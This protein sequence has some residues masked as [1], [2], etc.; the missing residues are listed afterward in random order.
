MDILNKKIKDFITNKTTNLNVTYKDIQSESKQL[1]KILINVYTKYNLDYN[2]IKLEDCS[3]YKTYKYANMPEFNIFRY[4]ASSHRYMITDINFNVLH[5]DLPSLQNIVALYPEYMEYSEIDKDIILKNFEIKITKFGKEPIKINFTS[6]NEAKK[7][8]LGQEIYRDIE[9]STSNIP[10]GDPTKNLKHIFQTL[11]TKE[12]VT[13][14]K[15]S[16]DRGV[17]LVKIYYIKN[18]NKEYT[19]DE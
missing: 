6:F 4:G 1:K 9:Y 7:L 12:F 14:I 15:Y 19:N 3:I 10:I 11:H 5:K 18:N 8:I 13:I 17:T 16:I 2:S